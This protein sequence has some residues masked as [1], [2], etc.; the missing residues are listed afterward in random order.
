M[1]YDFFEMFN[2]EFSLGQHS[3]G[4]WKSVISIGMSDGGHRKGIGEVS[5]LTTYKSL[6]KTIY[7][8]QSRDRKMDK[9]VY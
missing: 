2:Y 4:N 7:D 5:G 6:H 9:L 1:F 8:H 3:I